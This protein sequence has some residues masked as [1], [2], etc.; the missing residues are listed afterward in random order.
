MCDGNIHSI[1]AQT[2]SDRGTTF[3]SL[4][5]GQPHNSLQNSEALWF[6]L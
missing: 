3:C 4:T 1:Q 6:Y 2:A 5:V